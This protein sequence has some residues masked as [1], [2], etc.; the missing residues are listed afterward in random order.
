[1]IDLYHSSCSDLKAHV[2][3]GSVDLIFTDPPYSSDYLDCWSDLADFSVYALRPGGSLVSMVPH[4]HLPKILDLLDVP[5]LDFHWIMSYSYPLGFGETRILTKRVICQWK[6]LL[7][8]VKGKF[9]FGGSFSPDVF[10]VRRVSRDVRFHRWGQD[11]YGIYQVISSLKDG[12][13][14]VCDPFL[15]GGT[16]ALV[17]A[18]LSL[19]FVGGDVDSDCLSTTR[20]RLLNDGVE[21]PLV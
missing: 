18:A 4:Y 19:D 13:S 12:V 8:F 14:L 15:G 17:C 1:M 7:W 9:S 20:F 2:V 3:E 11:I 5:G 6:P 10:V 16:T 21:V